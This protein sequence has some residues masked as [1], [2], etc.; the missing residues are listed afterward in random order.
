MTVVS[1]GSAAEAVPSTKVKVW[2]PATRLFHWTLVALIVSAYVTRNYSDDPTLYWHRMNGYAVLVLLLF[3]TFWGLVGSSTSRFVSFVPRP[4]KVIGYARAL[5]TGHRLH[6]LGHNP[7]GSAVI[8]LMLLAVAAQAAT[9][10]FTSDDTIAQG[11]LHDHVSDM[12]SG[13]AASYHAKGFWIVLGLATVHIVANATYQFVFRD[14][15]ITSMITG[16]KPAGHYID[17]REARLAPGLR[18]VACLLFAVLIV[19][20]GVLLAGESLLH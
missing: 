15:L 8:L 10:L 2:D 1:R 7:L 9:G 14:R 6:Y 20:G 5:L 12:V 13:R 3:R 19:A 17:A 11:P 16:T 4:G 18:A